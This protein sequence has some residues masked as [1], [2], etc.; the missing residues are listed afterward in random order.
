[1]IWK[2]IALAVLLVIYVEWGWPFFIAMIGTSAVIHLIYRIV[3]GE[4][5]T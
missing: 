5:M 2:A 4:W 1:M 3:T